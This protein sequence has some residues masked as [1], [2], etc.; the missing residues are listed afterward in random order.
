MALTAKFIFDFTNF[1]D[2]I[3]KAEVELKTFET[4]AGKVQDALTRM[5]NS[6]SGQKIIQDATLMAA[7]VEKVGGVSKLTEAE[8]IR[9]GNV[10][11]EAAEKMRALGL[12]VPE[13]LQQLATAAKTAQS[14]VAG[15]TDTVNNANI[16]I[17]KLIT[18]YVGAQAIIGAAKSAWG[19]LTSTISDS[20]KAAG[21]AEKSHAQVAAA[22]RAQGTAVPSV[23]SAYQRYATELQ[24]VTTYQDDAVESAE[25]L[26]VTVGNV[27]PRDMEKALKATTELAAGLGKDLPEAAMLVAKAA[28]GN[29]GALKKAGITIDDTKVKAE[30][31]GYVLDQITAKFG[32]QAAALAGT[33]EGR[34]QQ[35]GNTWNNVEES[36][37]RAITTNETVLTLI[38]ELNGSIDTNTG[39]LKDNATAANLVSD[40]VIGAVKG[41][42]LL[43]KALDYFN[44]IRAGVVI[45]LRD[46]ALGST[47]IAKAT[48]EAARAT[49]FA[50][51]QLATLEQVKIFLKTVNQDLAD[52]Q[53]KNAD[54]VQGTIDFGNAVSTITAK[55]DK[56]AEDLEKTRGRVVDFSAAQDEANQKTSQ[57]AR[58]FA[59]MSDATVE[60]IKYELEHGKSLRYI[61]NEY[62][63]TAAQVNAV[64]QVWE[65]HTR[66]VAKN[67]AA[68]KKAADDWKAFA[69]NVT[70]AM[71]SIPEAI[72]EISGS[73][74]EAIR[75]FLAHGK[76]VE[77][78]AK[79]YGLFKYQVEAVADDM[80]FQQ[81]VTEATNKVFKNFGEVTVPN[82]TSQQQQL[83]YALQGLT[84]DG[85][86]PLADGFDLA[87]A[88]ARAL[89]EQEKRNIK[90]AQTLADAVARQSVGLAPNQQPS[91]IIPQAAAKD[92][93]DDARRLSRALNDVASMLD[94]VN[95]KWTE[96]GA[97]AARTVDGITKS[98]ERGDWI[99]AIT[100]GV[101]GAI[102]AISKLGG[103]SKLEQEGRKLE[104]SFEQQFKGFDDMMKKIAESYELTGRTAA[105]ARRDVTALMDAERRGGDAVQSV[106]DKINQ[107]LNI[108]DAIADAGYKTNAQL[109]QAAD[110]TRQIFDT[111][112]ASGQFNQEQLNKAYKAMQQAMADAGDA[113]AAAWIKAQDDAE[114]GAEKVKTALDDLQ[115]KRDD[116]AK[117][118]EQEAPEE[119]MGVIE[120]QIR[121][122][123]AALD[124]QIKAA[125]ESTAQASEDAM[126]QATSNIDKHAT[127][128]YNGMGV[129]IEKTFQDSATSVEK[130]FAVAADGMAED[131]AKQADAGARAIA[132]RFDGF[133]I[134]IPIVWDVPPLPGPVSLTPTPIKMAAGGFG[135]ADKPMLFSTQGNEYFAFS[136]EGKT[137]ATMMQNPVTEGPSLTELS[138]L[139]TQRDDLH[140]A[141]LRRVL[142]D[143]QMSSV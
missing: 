23:I 116:L 47:W 7:A 125:Q 93:E 74:V 69:S 20:I 101:T 114:K 76:S 18:S 44:L 53:K 91:G 132:A 127:D 98:L 70:G 50:T 3:R 14:G 34:L 126:K 95:N 111:M 135:Y 59:T 109:Q 36:I 46:I 103:P 55:A 10:A 65:T 88:H 41:F 37:G 15:L 83:Q 99:G 5:S 134:S 60:A 87:E 66:A 13:N 24:K 112:L 123:M 77:D 80:K 29:T 19:L 52:L 130:S 63:V 28:E 38:D 30:G 100:A 33:Y 67:A 57:T 110:Q 71:K 120:T 115:K 143:A 133:S 106:I 105:Q 117:Q 131:F 119:V 61:T 31:F 84:E 97:I 16:S 142:R 118:V 108:T 113:A 9:V 51:G 86:I 79:Y 94:S 92:S 121:G 124:A 48:L 6:L 26:L 21:E 45:G 11:A 17:G 141:S 8:L 22:L 39:E 96:M 128:T 89:E 25:A 4:G 102:E 129:K 56:L 85:L 27:M 139:L 73:T 2:A 40:A 1:S 75:Y 32:G 58:M 64:A 12:R 140:I 54:T 43:L 82:L 122:Q 68:G 137:F 35:L 49:A 104:A 81:S 138:R 136:G 72:D 78:L 107:S 42:S 90:T 62:G